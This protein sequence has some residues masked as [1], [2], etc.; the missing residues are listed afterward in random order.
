[1]LEV[2]L[3]QR[4]HRQLK[5]PSNQHHNSSS[6]PIETLPPELPGGHVGV[7][8]GDQDAGEAKHGGPA[9]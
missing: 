6:V 9:I 5:C 3:H 4:M 1:M 2:L 8:L 7:E